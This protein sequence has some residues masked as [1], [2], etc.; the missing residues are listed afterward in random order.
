MKKQFLILFVFFA[1]QTG[2]AQIIDVF[3]N[4]SYTVSTSVSKENFDKDYLPSEVEIYQDKIELENDQSEKIVLAFKKIVIENL[5]NAVS[6]FEINAAVKKQLSTANEISINTRENQ[7]LENMELEFKKVSIKLISVVN[8][9]AIYVVNYNFEARNSSDSNSFKKLF[10]NHFYA[11][12]LNTGAIENIDIKPNAEQQ[13]TL[14]TLT[15]SEFQKIYLLQ[16]EKLELNDAERIKNPISIDTTFRKMIDYSEAVI[17]PYAAGVMIQFPAYSK[18]SKILE[19]KAFRLLL[20]DAELQSL[21]VKFPKL[22]KYFIQHLLPASKTTKENL[23]DE[24]INLSKFSQGPEELEVLKMFDFNKKIYELKIE[25][26]QGINDEKKLSDSKIFRFNKVQTIHLIETRGS[27]DEIH[28]EEKFTYTNFQKVETATNS[29]YEKS[30]TLYFY[31]DEDFLY[32]EKIQIDKQESP[33]DAYIQTD[34]EITQ[35]HLI[36]ND[37]YR[38]DLRFNIVGDLKENVFSRHISENTVCGDQ[39]CLIFDAQHHVV[40]IK[41]LRSGSIEILTDADG[42]VL[43]SYFDSDRHHYFFSY[44][45]KNRVTEVKHLENG[46]LKDTTLYQYNQSETNPLRISKK[47]EYSTEHNY[48]IKFWD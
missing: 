1:F 29:A 24:Q 17:F 14:E 18:S 39:H 15:I 40:G 16:T 38:Y 20:R 4:K 27:K 30:L 21:V 19:G 36:F 44:D 31:K 11:A 7:Q 43:E 28:S 45:N 22:K 12:N 8:D 34:L 42:K 35:H 46:K 13:K 3:K 25:N 5:E 41:V 47:N 10:T 2:F 6:F 37:N 23:T 33:Y 9:F 26:F 32:S 48:I